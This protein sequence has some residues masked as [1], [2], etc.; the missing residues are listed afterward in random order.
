MRES[1]LL[2]EK[3]FVRQFPKQKNATD[4]TKKTLLFEHQYH[5]SNF[6]SGGNQIKL[7]LIKDLNGP[8]LLDGVYIKLL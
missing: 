7:C 3:P 8:K 5:S 4:L 6:I 2:S 1:D